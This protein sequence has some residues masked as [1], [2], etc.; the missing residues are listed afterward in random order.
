MSQYVQTWAQEKQHCRILIHGRDQLASP[1]QLRTQR[2]ARKHPGSKRIA[3]GIRYYYARTDT[4]KT[5]I[6]DR[7]AGSPNLPG[8]HL[9][10]NPPDWYLASLGSEHCIDIVGRDGRAKKRWVPRIV[11]SPHGREEERKDNHWF[12]CECMQLAVAHVMK[13]DALQEEKPRKNTSAG[14]DYLSGMSSG[15]SQPGGSWL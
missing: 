15:F 3:A 5:M 9:F 1:I 11:V 10:N 13:Y 8:W 12:D 2:D 4:W 6:A 14:A 7:I